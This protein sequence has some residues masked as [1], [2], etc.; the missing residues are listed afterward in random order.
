MSLDFISA[1]LKARDRDIWLAIHYAEARR[2][3]ALIALFA[4]ECEFAH[5]AASTTEAMVG[6]IRMA[7]WR[8]ALCGLDQGK[9]PAQPLLVLLAEYAVPNDVQGADLALLED[10]WLGMIGDEPV[11]Q[12]HVEGGGTLFALAARLLGGNEELG[13]QLGEA[14]GRGDDWGGDAA[15]LPRV[16]SS[17]RPLLGLVRLSARDRAAAKDAPPEP[18]GSLARQ[19][20]LLRAVAFG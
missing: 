11:P 3:P 9:V 12:S 14:W 16:P 8:E 13:R 7:W 15:G 6:E 18:R 1:E 19:W 20:Q 10:R 2:R 4:L 5:V 17:L